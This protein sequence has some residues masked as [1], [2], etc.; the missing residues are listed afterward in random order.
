MQSLPTALCSLGL[1]QSFLA[2]SI[3]ECELHQSNNN[4]TSHGLIC[5]GSRPSRSRLVLAGITL[6]PLDSSLIQFRLLPLLFCFLRLSYSLIFGMGI[7]PLTIRVTPRPRPFFA[8]LVQ[9]VALVIV[10]AT[11]SIDIAWNY[12]TLTPISTGSTAGVVNQG[13]KHGYHKMRF[14]CLIWFC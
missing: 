9:V 2:G 8:L 6:F 13:G 7:E 3:V 12:F 14:L 4:G 11:P 1:G 10:L 5:I